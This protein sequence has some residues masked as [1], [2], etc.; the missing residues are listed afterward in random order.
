M[1]A[2]IAQMLELNDFYVDPLLLRQVK[3]QQRQEA[4]E[5]DEDDPEE[6]AGLPGTQR[7]RPEPI[8][9]DVDEDAHEQ[10]QNRKEIAK[11]KR[12]RAQSRGVSA[13]PS[14]RTEASTEPGE[15]DIEMM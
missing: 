14:H 7:T 10:E 8:D 9:S 2:N 5:D 11:I 12:E 4:H 1:I 13:A 3:R 6:D 15:S